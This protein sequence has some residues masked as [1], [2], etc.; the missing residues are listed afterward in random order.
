MQ[1]RHALTEEPWAQKLAETPDGESYFI[2]ATI[3]RAHQDAMV[4]KKGDP[5]RSVIPEEAP[6][7]R[8]MLLWTPLEM[9]FAS[10]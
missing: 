7:R 10:R 2:D 3:V 1:K 6:P 9:R 8:F 5:K 4:A